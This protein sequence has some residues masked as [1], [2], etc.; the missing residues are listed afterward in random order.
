M[1]TKLIT[2]LIFVFTILVINIQSANSQVWVQRYNGTADSTDNAAAMTVDASG[3]IYVTGLT[4]SAG[5]AHYDMVT[6]KYNSDGNIMWLQKYNGPA[7]SSDYPSALVVDPSGNVYVA[8]SSYGVGS[9]S[10]FVV[11]KYNSSGV[12]QWIQRY[13]GPAND[14]DNSY[15]LA[16]DASGNVYVT[17][18]S[19]GGASSYDYYTIK[20]NSAGVLQWGQRYNGTGN[21]FDSPSS[22]AVDNSG[23]V[24]I[25]GYSTGVGTGYDYLTIKYNSAGVQQWEQRYNGTGNSTD[26][27]FSLKIDGSAN[28]YITGFSGGSGSGNDYLT[29]K[30]NSA[31]VQQWLQRY[32]G[33][34][35]G[36]DIARSLMLDDSG[37]VY[38]SGY[39][40][41]STSGEDMT[42]IKYNSAGVQQWLQTYNGTGNSD[43]EAY[44]LTKDGSG[45]ILVTGFSTG[46]GTGHDYATLKYNAAGAPQWLQT[47]NGPTNNSDEAYA[48]AVD[49]S[50]FV[51]VSGGSRSSAGNDLTTV[52]FG[53]PIGIQTINSQVPDNFSLGQNYPNPFNPVTNIKFQIPGSGLVK[54]TVFDISGR[55]IAELV[56]RNLAAG[57][58]NVDFDAS[59]LSSGAYFYKME[60]MGFTEVKKMIL[61]K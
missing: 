38:I 40:T 20:Y 15:S 52:K 31:G 46:N 59:N 49:A 23:N 48:I 54:I 11:I 58:Y 26:N 57:T 53:Q 19:F 25:S 41:G 17:G 37:N 36:Y 8:G 14:G 47:Y 13:N 56:N 32:N 3:N 7:D 27:V 51:Y 39:T 44:A 42:T 5:G 18:T 9:K 2:F 34:G 60:T 50:G 21:S 4:L 6:I 28:V 10:D 61:I 45:N 12:Q 55:E 24:Y 16:V 1:K 22:L 29:I 35:N 43:D 30:Y 33:S